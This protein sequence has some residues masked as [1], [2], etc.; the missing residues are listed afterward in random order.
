MA[1]PSTASD[2]TIQ[3]GATILPSN[4]TNKTVSWSVING[5]GQ[6]TINTSGL[7]TPVVNGSVTVKATA[8]D[9]SGITGSF[10]MT[11]SKTSSFIQVASISVEPY[12]NLSP[13]IS[14]R[15][16]KLQMLALILPDYAT[17]KKVLWSVQNITGFATVDVNGLVTAKRN[18]SVKV[19]ATTTDGSNL[20]AYCL[21][22]IYNQNT[23]RTYYQQGMLVIASEGTGTTKSAESVENVMASEELI[24]E[25]E[26]V[27]YSIYNVQGH[28]VYS[29]RS[30]ET[31]V[32]IDI[33]NFMPGIYIVN[34]KGRDFDESLK[35]S[36]P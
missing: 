17:N 20:S 11:L 3:M 19:I 23:Y 28:M 14:K 16:G 24:Y 12:N 30:S 8:T 15:Y 27:Q 29:H 1:S 36:I 22:N 34:I 21:I 6:A 7:L 18:G 26:D 13:R 5:T 31:I 35:V 33:R 25:N 4:A 32:Q 2:N 10:Q 9:G